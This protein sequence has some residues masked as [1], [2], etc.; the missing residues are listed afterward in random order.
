MAT[1]IESA[2]AADPSLVFL[3]GG[4]AQTPKRAITIVLLGLLAD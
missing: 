4:F 1:Y 3:A 2:H